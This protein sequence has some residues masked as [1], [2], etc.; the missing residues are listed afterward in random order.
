MSASSGP[1]ASF[2][3]GSDTAPDASSYA[4]RTGWAGPMATYPIFL[5]GLHR[6]RCVVVG[7]GRIALEKV[8]GLLAG[9]AATVDVISPELIEPLRRLAGEGRV[10]HIARRFEAADLH[11]A[12]LVIAAT[13]EPQ[14]NRAVFE[15]AEAMGI[16]A[17]VVDDPPRCAFIMPSVLR[18]GGLTIA[19][20]TG[21]ASPALAVRL[22]ERL[23]EALGAEY[24]RF[25]ELAGALRP[26]IMDQIPDPAVR[27]RLWYALVDGE[28]LER[29]RAGDDEGAMAEAERLIAVA[30]E[31]SV[32]CASASRGSL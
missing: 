14:I 17:Q 32:E 15:E 10:R 31:E 1:P 21:G 24:E 7:G 18:R 19:I 5:V 27:K 26:R 30:R 2:S 6:R 13:D 28:V 4:E 9:G 22:R 29:L 25:V 23:Q 8:E 12:F 20:S 11:G 3:V 16:L